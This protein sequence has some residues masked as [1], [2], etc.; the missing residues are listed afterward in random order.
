MSKRIR[1]LE[2]LYLF[3]LIFIFLTITYYQFKYNTFQEILFSLGLFIFAFLLY[4][5]YRKEA[6]KNT[7]EFETLK[8]DKLGLEEKI[9][10]AFKH[11]GKLNVQVEE[12]HSVFNDI[13]KYPE[14]KNDLRYILNFLSGKVLAMT[15]ADWICFKIINPS[16]YKILAEYNKVRGNHENCNEVMPKVNITT[17]SLLAKEAPPGHTLVWSW[18]EKDGLNLRVFCILPKEELSREEKVFI[19]AIVNQLE[20][21]YL[22]FSSL[23]SKKQKTSIDWQN[24]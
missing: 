8:Q 20:M 22:I 21:F 16:A 7:F 12:I 19:K 1:V 10:E 17:D 2:S 23:K 6:D 9:D 4:G 5:L 15:N 11:I 3:L 18:A 13:K 14:N 24:N